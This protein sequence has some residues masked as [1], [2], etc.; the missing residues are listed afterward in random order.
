MKKNIVVLLFIFM[1]ISV[2][3]VCNAA[4][5]DDI[6][7]RYIDLTLDNYFYDT[8]EINGY[9]DYHTQAILYLEQLLDCQP[10][11]WLLLFKLSDNK[12]SLA[13]YL[14]MKENIKE[15]EREYSE[16][17]MEEAE[18]YYRRLDEQKESITLDII[19]NTEESD[20]IKAYRYLTF[21]LMNISDRTL[22]IEAINRAKALA[23]QDLISYYVLLNS[24][25]VRFYCEN[26]LYPTSTCQVFGTGDDYLKL[27]EDID[28]EKLCKEVISALTNLKQLDI[29]D[30][31]KQLAESRAAEANAF[32]AYSAYFRNDL[33][34]LIFY[35]DQAYTQL[36]NMTDES[37][38]PAVFYA[39][40]IY[41]LTGDLMEDAA[42]VSE[43][44]DIFLEAYDA[45]MFVHPIIYFDEM[46]IDPI[47]YN[48]SD[49]VKKY[50]K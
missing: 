7:N 38:L 13:S 4:T 26:S 8:G 32:L 11:D 44:L 40:H 18:Y 48:V 30:S 2:G 1:A 12:S 35:G 6:W 21:A 22:S 29:S 50:L 27:Y 33:E 42:I 25:V 10:D 20:K 34:K 47:I 19:H 9:I 45:C 39:S 17:L 23:E 37:T 15:E 46:A 31:L 43:A 3:T 36:E 16:R 49:I 28:T 41:L 14:Y 24:M 5:V